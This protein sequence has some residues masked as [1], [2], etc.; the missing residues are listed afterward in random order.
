ME[1]QMKLKDAPIADGFTLFT[2]RRATKASCGN[3]FWL[4][5]I[6]T[7]RD[8]AKLAG[9]SNPFDGRPK[10]TGVAPGWR[11]EYASGAIVEGDETHVAIL[12]PSV[13]L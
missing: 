7:V 3:P 10:L 9:L 1:T 5:Y 6:W 2:V 11:E 8:D 12:H 13:K 4:K